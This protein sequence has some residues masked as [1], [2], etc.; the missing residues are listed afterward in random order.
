MIPRDVL[1]RAIW[2]ANAS[3]LLMIRGRGRNADDGASTLQ[4]ESCRVRR[5]GRSDGLRLKTRQIKWVVVQVLEQWGRAIGGR[6]GRSNQATAWPRPRLSCLF[7]EGGT[8][9]APPPHYGTWRRRSCAAHRSSQLRIRP[10]AGPGQ[11]GDEYEAS[12][13]EQ[14]NIS[15]RL[16]RHY[17]ERH[18]P[19]NAH[20]SP[21]IFPATTGATGYNSASWWRLRKVVP[22]QEKKRK[23]TL[24]S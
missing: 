2:F 22:S 17:L 16:A 14:W 1:A 15:P 7:E 19:R 13:R 24:R 5:N 10:P 21:F 9:A 23:P 8:A 3:G 6:T 4:G 11:Q 20:D 18:C 12:D